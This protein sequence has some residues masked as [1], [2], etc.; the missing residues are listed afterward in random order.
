VTDE[1]DKRP[2]INSPS[3]LLSYMGKDRNLLENS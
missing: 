1:V 2:K 3:S